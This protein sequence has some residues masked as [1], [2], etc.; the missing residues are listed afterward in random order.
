MPR[1]FLP[2][3]GEAVRQLADGR[4][5]FFTKQNPLGEMPSASWR[6]TEGL[7]LVV[8]TII[9][10]IPAYSSTPVFAYFMMK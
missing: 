4:G 8:Y 2:L 5:V 1:I 7:Y 10:Y 9:L 6:K 3:V